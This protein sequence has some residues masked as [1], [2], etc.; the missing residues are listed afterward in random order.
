MSQKDQIT[1]RDVADKAGVSVAT[2]SRVLNNEKCVAEDTFEK[3]KAVIE[4]ENYRP[5]LLGRNLRRTQTNIILVLTVSIEYPYFTA[6]IT[7]IEQT[8][9]KYDYNVILCNTNF[10]PQREYRYL[11]MMRTKLSDGAIF[12]SPTISARE[13]NDIG[14]LHPVVQCSE[15]R[16]ETTVSQVSI[17]YTAAAAE[18]VR[19]LYA[20]G[21]RRIALISANH[22]FMSTTQIEIGYSNALAAVGLEKKTHIVRVTDYWYNSGVEAM[23]QLLHSDDR[24]DA[25]LCVGDLLAIGAIRAIKQAGLSVP[26]DIAVVG[27]DDIEQAKQSDPPLTSI[28]IPKFE[29]GKT[30][31]ELLIAQIKGEPPKRVCLHHDLVTRASTIG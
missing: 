6:V 28:S 20:L 31:V 19:H 12:L 8:A 21:R 15:M 26:G 9:L 7:G 30:A 11:D 4:R 14:K 16:G 24:P 13:I 27:C 3:V 17:D 2:V 1:I 5:N 25:V 18:A 22:E 10:E 23:Q 29:I